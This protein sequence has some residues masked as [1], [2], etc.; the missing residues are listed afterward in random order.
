MT[1]L[2][3]LSLSPFPGSRRIADGRPEFWQIPLQKDDAAKNELIYGA[4]S[5]PL[6]DS[7][8]ILRLGALIYDVIYELIYG[9]GRCHLWQDAASTCVP[10]LREAGRGIFRRGASAGFR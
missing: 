8:G 3:A 1:A 9:G 7:R 10:A 4:G 6:N 5:S 2:R